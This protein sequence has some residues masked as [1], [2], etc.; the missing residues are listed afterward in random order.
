MSICL[1]LSFP[2]WQEQESDLYTRG[3]WKQLKK[4]KKKTVWS[5]LHFRKPLWLPPAEA[6]E[7]R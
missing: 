3:R 7:G 2:A 1:F 4:F 6:S 5:D